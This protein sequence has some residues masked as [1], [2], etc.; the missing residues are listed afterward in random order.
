M[1]KTLTVIWAILTLAIMTA[2][3][4]TMFSQGTKEMPGWAG[5]LLFLL[6]AGIPVIGGGAILVFR[7]LPDKER[8]RVLSRQGGIRFPRGLGPFPGKRCRPVAEALRSAGFTDIRC[9]DPDGGI[10]ETLTVD[11]ETGPFG[12]R[13][14][15]PDAPVVITCKK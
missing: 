12:G 13:M 6:Y 2:A 3:V 7:Y 14:Y 8:E 11:G 5:G 15:R 1:R 4:V 9:G 10:I